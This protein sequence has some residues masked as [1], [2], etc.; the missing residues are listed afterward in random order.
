MGRHHGQDYHNDMDL[1]RRGRE[2]LNTVRNFLHSFSSGNTEDNISA[3]GYQNV[4]VLNFFCLL[5]AFIQD[6]SS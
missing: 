1:T 5:F 3:L 4:N 6:N 2:T